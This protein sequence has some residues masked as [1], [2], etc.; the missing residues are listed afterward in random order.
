MI[1]VLKEK[2]E[3]HG[4]CAMEPPGKHQHG[5]ERNVRLDTGAQAA[6]AASVWKTAVYQSQK[7]GKRN[8]HVKARLAVTSVI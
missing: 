3:E 6:L 4:R 8:S 2:L 7:K 1:K 5:C